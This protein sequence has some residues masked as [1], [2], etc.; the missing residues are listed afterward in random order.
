VPDIYS[1]HAAAKVRCFAPPKALNDLVAPPQT[2]RGR[3]APNE[4]IIVG[5]PGTEVDIKAH[6]EQA[7]ASLG[8]RALVVDH[9]D[10][11]S[12]FTLHGEAYY[13]CG[14][15]AEYAGATGKH[16][17]GVYVRESDVTLHVDAWLLRC[18]TR[19]TST[20]RTRPSPPHKRPTTG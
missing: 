7:L 17:Q 10:G 16:A 2:L 14:Y 5:A 6:C 11:W 12:F 13:R 8:T 18:S 20:R 1:C 19:R 3:I 4:L 9:T 15:A